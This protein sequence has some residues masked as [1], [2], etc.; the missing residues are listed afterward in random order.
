[1]NFQIS[2]RPIGGIARVLFYGPVGFAEKMEAAARLVEKYRHRVPLRVLLD[3][4]YARSKVTLE[5]QR[6]FTTYIAEHPVLRR[7]YIAVLH[8]RSRCT[9]PLAT[10]GTCLCRHS[11]RE[12]VAEAEAEAWLTQ[13][14]GTVRPVAF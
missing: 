4:R 14:K 3:L 13:N 2:Y 8:P 12:F 9:S 6:K 1:M 11:S 7:A 10:Q 5:E